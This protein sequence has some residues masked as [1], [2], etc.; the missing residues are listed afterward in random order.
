MEQVLAMRKPLTVVAI[1]S[2]IT[3]TITTFGQDYSS[4][5]YMGS[6]LTS[7]YAYSM[8]LALLG[9]YK[10]HF[11]TTNKFA[12]YMTRSSFGL[13]VVHYIIIASVGYYLKSATELPVAAIYAILLAAECKATFK[14]I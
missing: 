7:L 8:I 2:G 1:T 4:A 10:H 12:D 13:Y 14:T 5:E 9:L 3:L 11:D 6:A